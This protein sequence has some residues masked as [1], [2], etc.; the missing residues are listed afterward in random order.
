LIEG[1]H[2]KG[3]CPLD[4]ESTE[5]GIERINNRRNLFFFEI[6]KRWWTVGG[7]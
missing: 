3:S 2:C 5:V 1:L 4:P 7:C 6:S